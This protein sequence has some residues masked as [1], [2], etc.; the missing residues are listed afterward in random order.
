[1]RLI[2]KNTLLI[3]ILAILV[4]SLFIL[5][6]FETGLS[7]NYIFLIAA[8]IIT[9]IGMYFSR[10]LQKEIVKRSKPQLEL[11]SSSL[12]ENPRIVF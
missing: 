4:S 5:L 1:M 3:S 12:N 9:V 11:P 7:K 8:G 6:Y 2:N 10:Y